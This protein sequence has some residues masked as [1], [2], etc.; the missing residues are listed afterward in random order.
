MIRTLLGHIVPLLL[1]VLVFF[2]TVPFIETMFR[3]HRAA[4][5]AIEWHGVEVVSKVVR[6]GDNL[7]IVYTATINKQCPSDLRGFIVTEDGSVP[8]RYPTV[9]G[10]YSRPSNLPVEIRVR[11]KVPETADPGLAPFVNGEHVSRATATR[12]CPD[13]VETDNSIPDAPFTLEVSEP[14]L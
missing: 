11:I 8:V 9:A 5:A 14:Q 12:Y 6:P 3:V 10:G 4:Q 2:T 13:G 1:A 7:E